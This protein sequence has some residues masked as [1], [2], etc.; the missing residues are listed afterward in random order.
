MAIFISVRLDEQACSRYDG[1]RVLLSTCPVDIFREE[2]GRVV[3]AEEN[4]DEC[5]LC[6]LCWEAVPEAVVVEKLY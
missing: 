4:V 2:E 5:T 6:G 1:C 3:I